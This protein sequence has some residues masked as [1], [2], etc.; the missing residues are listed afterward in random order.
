M[1]FSSK[2]YSNP[3]D[4]ICHRG[5]EKY[6]DL[7][8]QLIQFSE[9]IENMS[10]HIRIIIFDLEWVF[11]ETIIPTSEIADNSHEFF[12]IIIMIYNFIFKY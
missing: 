2:T 5:M 4:T 3:M 1:I 7:I 8:I 11:I 9:T 6:F 12:G 10:T